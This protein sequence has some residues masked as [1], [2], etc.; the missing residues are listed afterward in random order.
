MKCV[1]G[2]TLVQI[3]Y[4]LRPCGVTA[5]MRGYARAFGEINKGSR[6]AIVFVCGEGGDL[7][8]VPAAKIHVCKEMGYRG[9]RTGKSYAKTRDAIRAALLAVITGKN[10]PGPVTVVAHNMT[11]G[12]NC[13]LSSAFSRVVR[14]CN[15]LRD[16]IRFFSVVHDF[17]EEGRTSQLLQIQ[18]L[19]E[20]GHD[21][22]NDLYFSAPNFR[23]VAI[24]GRNR[25]VLQNAGCAVLLLKNPPGQIRPK[26]R[27]RKAEAISQLHRQAKKDG[28]S[29]LAGRPFLAC[30]TRI[31]V[32]K[33]PL[34]AILVAA[35]FTEAN[36]LLGSVRGASAANARLLA[37]CK[38]LCAGHSLPVLFDTN[39]AFARSDADDLVYACCDAVLSTS[40]AEGFGYSLTESVRH[41]KPL[42][43]RRPQGINER[44]IGYA[45][46]LYENLWVP[47]AWVSTE[48]IAKRY[49]E[50]LKPLSQ[51][52]GITVSWESFFRKFKT[53]YCK[54]N[55]IDFGCL[56]MV[57]QAEIIERCLARPVA[58]MELLNS[59]PM[60]TAGLRYSLGHRRPPGKKTPFARENSDFVRRFENCF[61]SKTKARGVRRVRSAVVGDYFADLT[62]FKIAMTGQQ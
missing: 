50:L 42:V 38:K 3:H 1:G 16:D 23:Y 44:E 34:E 39:S 12:K 7:Q 43:G 62:K 56:D 27:I 37:L 32:R 36:L 4:H 40:V 52:R 47:V 35:V 13:A 31:A 30:P 57:S 26:M 5:V 8:T 24:N 18:S 55:A 14:Q 25:K 2:G 60:Q 10:V 49:F 15:G 54:K 17:A 11:L 61:C 48:R 45:R 20:L 28:V 6:H 22:R 58:K 29:F 33:N 51:W 19:E 21:I 46:L 41:G 9:F 53:A 59:F